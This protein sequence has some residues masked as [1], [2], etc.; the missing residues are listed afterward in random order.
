MGIVVL[1]LDRASHTMHFRQLTWLL[2]LCT[3]MCAVHSM[4]ADSNA[5]VST[6]TGVA[7]NNRREGYVKKSGSSFKYYSTN[8][9]TYKPTDCK[10]STRYY[11]RAFHRRRKFQTMTCQ[12]CRWFGL[13]CLT[14][15]VLVYSV[16]C[17]KGWFFGWSCHTTS[18]GTRKI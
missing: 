16:R 10:K 2:A 8:G 14:N 11:K 4:S 3:L 6:T 17:K 12:L 13:R 1:L 15:R 7:W 9:H 18:F 5:A